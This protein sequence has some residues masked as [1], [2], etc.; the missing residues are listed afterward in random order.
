MLKT[1]TACQDQVWTGTNSKPQNLHAFI[2]GHEA[3]CNVRIKLP[4]D[5]T[6]RSA[7]QVTKPFLPPVT[8]CEK[9]ENAT[10]RAA[11]RLD[12]S[13]APQGLEYLNS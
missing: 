8:F 11:D 1:Q 2:N 7:D 10:Q 5:S 9:C 6:L 13:M 4:V 3:A 12:A